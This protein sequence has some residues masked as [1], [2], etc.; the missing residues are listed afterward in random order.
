MF[1]RYYSYLCV[2]L[3]LSYICYSSSYILENISTTTYLPTYDSSVI[4]TIPSGI[5]YEKPPTIIYTRTPKI[6][7]NIFNY[8][9]IVD[10]IKEN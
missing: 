1:V 3:T 7:A 4:Q 9:S 2:N 8:K 6:T 5:D 10:E